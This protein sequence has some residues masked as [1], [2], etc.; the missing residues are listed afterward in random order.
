M[1]IALRL[2]MVILLMAHRQRL[3]HELFA[4]LGIN[5][6]AH[7]VAGR[8]GIVAENLPHLVE[9]SNGRIQKIFGRKPR[10]LRSYGRNMLICK[11]RICRSLRRRFFDLKPQTLRF[12]DNGIL[13]GTELFL[14]G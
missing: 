8:C 2:L 5:A 12:L 9:Q 3:L 4:A 10:E 7:W 1:F 13:N 6:N 14:L 11:Q